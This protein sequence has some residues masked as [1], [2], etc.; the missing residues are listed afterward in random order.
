MTD[1]IP[2]KVRELIKLVEAVESSAGFIRLA[3]KLPDGGPRELRDSAVRSLLD[4]E[5]T[6]I[7]SMEAL[8]AD[9]L[10]YFN[11]DG[12]RNAR[13]IRKLSGAMVR[14]YL[15]LFFLAKD[16]ADG[17]LGNVFTD[18]EASITNYGTHHG[19]QSAV[20]E[21]LADM[22]SYFKTGAIAEINNALFPKTEPTSGKH[23]V[24]TED[25]VA[26]RADRERADLIERVKNS[27][28]FKDGSITPHPSE[29]GRFICNY[30]TIEELIVN[31]LDDFCL[32]S[33]ITNRHSWKKAG[34]M[35]YLNGELLTEQQ[36]KDA[37]HR[38]KKKNE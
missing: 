16:K 30:G 31:L 7:Q 14:S 38:W 20:R 26:T 23:T 5:K 10:E 32:T 3:F 22:D 2:A 11:R 24:S 29:D 33:T 8:E 12:F 13:L 17:K 15:N 27:Q 19:Y 28:E 4:K 9:F 1:S 35:F 37:D 34:S 36:I 25:K 21:W 6:T 18:E